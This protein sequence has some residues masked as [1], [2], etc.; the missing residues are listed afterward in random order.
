[1]FK[2]TLKF[3][4]AIVIISYLFTSG[5]LDFS[6]V[7]KSLHNGYLPFLA[8]ACLLVQVSLSVVRWRILLH[9]KSHSLLPLKKMFAISWIGLFFNTFLPGIVTGDILKLVYCRDLD[10]NLDKTFLVT[11][12]LIDRIVGLV[13]L[14]SL[15][16]V[17]TVLGYQELASI[18]PK[19]SHVLHFNLLLFAGAIFVI[20][21]LFLPSKIQSTFLNISA[22]IPLVGA[23]IKKTLEQVWIMGNSRKQI[24]LTIGISFINQFLN[25]SAMYLLASPFF[26]KPIPLA[27]AFSF[28]P[29]G[30]VAVAIP[31]SPAGAGVGHYI[32]DEL[33]SYVGI[34]GG[35]SL[36]NLYFISYVSIN[37]LGLFPYIFYG[38]RHSLHDAESFEQISS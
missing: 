6:L 16:G 2:M 32:F 10:K 20:V 18:S 3:I 26:S 38:K 35:A 7:E 5:K 31:I 28:I 22:T 24:S 25:V 27:H 14:L 11:S 37:L 17:F 4:F 29:I 15:M 34:S 36:F 21:L 8:F 33:F 9:T 23:R 30:F 19:L 12:V 13:G 1:M